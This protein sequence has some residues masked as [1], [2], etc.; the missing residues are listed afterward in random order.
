[1]LRNSLALVMLAAF[2]MAC[3]QAHH[4][5]GQTLPP[6][7]EQ[8]SDLPTQPPVPPG[9]LVRVARVIDGDTIELDGG[10]RVR[11]IGIDTAE[12]VDPSQPVGCLGKEASDR[13]K[14]LVSGQDGAHREGRVGL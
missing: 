3:T 2:V 7:V 5:T 14:A 8:S 11:Y 9:F 1:M 13:N 6:A 10:V 12:T 4:E